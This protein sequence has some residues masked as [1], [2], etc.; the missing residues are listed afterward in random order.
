MKCDKRI[1]WTN[2]SFI[3]ILC[4]LWVVSSVGCTVFGIR[5]VE[6][7]SYEVLGEYGQIEVRE[8]NELVIAETSVDAGYE[9][10][11]NI[12]FKRLFAYISGKNVTKVK[13][14]M[15]TP[16]M[17][18]EGASIDGEKVAMTTP[19][20][21]ERQEQGWR[22]GFVLPGSYSIEKA[23]VPSDPLVTLAVIPKKKVAVIR[24]S[25][26]WNEE[27]MRQKS[28]ELKNWI[29]TNRL[30]PASKPRSAGY[31]PP[32]TIPFLRRN[33]IMIDVH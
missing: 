3:G 9:E 7:A 4:A 29:R 28:N 5:T 15:T 32:W 19:V 26:S 10:A 24:Y 12:A 14:V 20:L 22:Y 23:P 31:D 8:Y 2:L 6:E 1:S 16:V 18:K 27:S 30:E 25:G 17:A 11:G 33:E 21:G 13:I